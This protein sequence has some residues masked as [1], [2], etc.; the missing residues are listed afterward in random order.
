MSQNEMT[1][2]TNK[3]GVPTR[4]EL[5]NL[6]GKLRYKSRFRNSLRST[7][8]SLITVAAV[9]V[10]GIVQVGGAY[11]LFSEGIR[12]TP[13]VAASLITGLEPIMN[14]TWVA[15][16]YGE[17]ISGLSLIG[18]VIVVGAILAYNIKMNQK[19]S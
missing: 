11:I 6:A 17:T 13:P 3:S 1:A 16:F 14:P 9:A 5:E 2:K 8:F 7:V 4:E 10:L 18:A 15:L 19:Q 12:N